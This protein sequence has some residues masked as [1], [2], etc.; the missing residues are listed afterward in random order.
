MLRTNRKP[1]FFFALAYYKYLHMNLSVIPL[2]AVWIS[3][4][5]T[6]G[7]VFQSL[8]VFNV[9]HETGQRANL[10]SLSH[11]PTGWCFPSAGQEWPTRTSNL[12]ILKPR[13]LH[14]YFLLLAGEW[15]R[16]MYKQV[17]YCQSV[18]L[19]FSRRQ[20]SQ[21]V[22]QADPSTTFSSKYNVECSILT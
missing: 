3:C 4:Y 16:V 15:L 21:Q 17:L 1:F 11:P 2:M 8:L 19:P 14:F 5:C 10:P 7:A 18:F 22:T 9:H 20:V 12:F 13:G 6:D